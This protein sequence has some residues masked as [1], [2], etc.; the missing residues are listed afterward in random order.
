MGAIRLTKDQRLAIRKAKI[1]YKSFKRSKK[2]FVI[3]GVAGSG[4]T[5]V[6][7]YLVNELNLDDND[8]AYMSFTGKAV[9]VLNQKSIPAR[10]I[11]STIYKC[12]PVED[13]DTK[14]MVLKTTIREEPY[15]KKL[16]MIDEIS[17]VSK[18]IMNDI[19]SFGKPVICLGD[20]NQLPPIGENNCHEFVINPDVRLTESIR[21]NNG[22]AILDVANNALKT[23][24]LR[25]GKIGN[26]V[27]ILTTPTRDMLLNC[28]QVV[29]ATN[30][31]R[32]QLN[33][34][35]RKMQGIDIDREPYPL[36]GEK[37]ISKINNWQESIQS[38]KGYGDLFLINGLVGYGL[39]DINPHND[40]LTFK[41]Y[42]HDIA[43]FH[44]IKTEVDF[45]TEEEINIHKS[46][47]EDKKHTFDYAY[48][49]TCHASQGSEFD[50]VVIYASD[51]W[52]SYDMRRKWLYTAITR[53][54]KKLTIII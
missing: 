18:D 42:Y 36:R 41:P 33:N 23:H 8:I 16:F 51:M 53:A 45:F 31:K 26:N 35:F 39:N 21:H 27:R 7:R 11:H 30:R 34:Y 9:D 13:P 40:Y 50:H 15:L 48:A 52:G 29:V 17:M 46:L 54:K 28:D 19:L 10:T 3:S 1:Y 12:H 22:N 44:S 37:L 38:E 47:Y 43:P 24:Y 5:T 6:I 14:R 20:H 2:P 4:K 32:V 25:K 49:I